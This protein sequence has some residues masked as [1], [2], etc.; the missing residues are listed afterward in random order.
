MRAASSADRGADLAF[1]S[2]YP[3]ECEYLYK[4]LAYLQLVGSPKKLTY[5]GEQVTVVDVALR[6]GPVARV[7]GVVDSLI[8]PA[9]KM[10]AAASQ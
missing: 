2:C 10:A 9:I 7:Q 3:A 6:S 5:H 8:R 1:L 4:P